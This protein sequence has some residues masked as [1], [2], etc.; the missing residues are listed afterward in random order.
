[1]IAPTELGVKPLGYWAF[2]SED[3]MTRGAPVNAFK[4][5]RVLCQPDTRTRMGGATA[6]RRGSFLQ[7]RYRMLR[8]ISRSMLLAPSERT[9]LL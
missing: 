5:R 2:A 3:T 8:S 6:R 4:R 1:M 9:P 7:R